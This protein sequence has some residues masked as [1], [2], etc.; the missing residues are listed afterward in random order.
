M[1]NNP[2]YHALKGLAHRALEMQATCPPVK[3]L[4]FLQEYCTIEINGSRM[5][6]HST[7]VIQFLQELDPN[8]WVPVF[9]SEQLKKFGKDLPPNVHKV[10]TLS[11]ATVESSLARLKGVFKVPNCF[12]IDNA[13]Y[14][15]KMKLDTLMQDILAHSFSQREF[16]LILVG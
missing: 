8:K 3:P 2:V 11:M 14:M 7:G 13:K 10:N 15:S 1:K 4:N 6:G 5:S 12:V 9:C 16:L